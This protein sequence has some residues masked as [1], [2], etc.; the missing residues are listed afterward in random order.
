MENLSTFKIQE[1]YSTPAGVKFTVFQYGK[2]ILIVAYTHSIE[3][4]KYGIGYKCN[5]PLNCYNTVTAI[6]GNNGSSGQFTLFDNV[7]TVQSTDSRLP[8]KNTFMGQLTT[9]LK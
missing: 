7:L 8:L 1:F 5:L 9:F 2:L 3:E 4:L 6:T